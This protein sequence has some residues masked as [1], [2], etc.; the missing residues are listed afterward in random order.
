MDFTDLGPAMTAAE[1]RDAKDRVTKLA[2]IVKDLITLADNL[3]KRIHALE[4]E[5]FKD[6][7]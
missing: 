6:K 7:S 5:V 3:N 2:D 1:G 4:V